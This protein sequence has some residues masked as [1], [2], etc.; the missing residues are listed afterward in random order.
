[1]AITKAVNRNAEGKPVGAAFSP[2]TPVLIL[3][4]PVAVPTEFESVGVDPTTGSSL[5][6]RGTVVGKERVDAC[7][8]I[9]DGWKVTSSQTFTQAGGSRVSDVE[10]FV[11]TQLG[12]VVIFQ[13]AVASG[14]V[15]A[16]TDPTVIDHLAQL[17]PTPPS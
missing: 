14:A 5:S 4:L 16:A 12:G 10:Y 13:K 9:V 2:S 15:R 7:G 1:V 17:D 6:I 3:P 8:D 11:A